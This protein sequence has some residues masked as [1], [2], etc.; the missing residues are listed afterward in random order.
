MSTLRRFPHGRILRHINSCGNV[1]VWKSEILKIDMF[2]R[3]EAKDNE[4]RRRKTMRR[5]G[6]EAKGEEVKGERQ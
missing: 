2:F 5:R 1:G 4:A 3:R 6:E